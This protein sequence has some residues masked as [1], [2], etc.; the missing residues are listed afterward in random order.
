M[1]RDAENERCHSRCWYLVN[2]AGESW[3]STLRAQLRY[4]NRADA[5]NRVHSVDYELSK[6]VW[7]EDIQPVTVLLAVTFEN[8]ADR[9]E[10][11]SGLRVYPH[12]CLIACVERDVT[13]GFDPREVN[14]L[15]SLLLEAGAQLVLFSLRH[16]G[17]LIDTSDKHAA[18]QAL[19]KKNASTELP[20]SEHLLEPLPWQSVPWA[21]G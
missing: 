8:L 13:S 6:I 21:I 12:L 19:A 9:L 7:Q 5:A 2:E 18:E 3:A 14:R 10:T 17:K 20:S 15:E 1:N 11:F 4:S 16:I